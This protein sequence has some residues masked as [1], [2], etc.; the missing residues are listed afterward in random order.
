[1]PH[2]NPEH[3]LASSR[4]TNA[5]PVENPDNSDRYIGGRMGV[6]ADRRVGEKQGSASRWID[7]STAPTRL[8]AGTQSSH[9]I[10]MLPHM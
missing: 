1:V 7:L 2:P 4:S 8:A 6:T 9:R 3:R 10:N 5:N